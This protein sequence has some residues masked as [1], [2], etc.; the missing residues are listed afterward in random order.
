MMEKLLQELEV[1]DI[2]RERGITTLDAMMGVPLPALA[3]YLEDFDLAK[4]VRTACQKRLEVRGVIFA[5]LKS[6]D[7]DFE[8]VEQ[9]IPAMC[10]EDLTTNHY[11]E[12]YEVQGWASNWAQLLRVTAEEFL[13]RRKASE[14]VTLERID[15]VEE[16][17]R[18]AIGHANCE[19]EWAK[20]FILQRGAA[21][22]KECC[23]KVKEE[24]KG[25]DP[26][27][28][29]NCEAAHVTSE[30]EL[31]RA[32]L[33]REIWEKTKDCMFKTI[34]SAQTGMPEKFKLTYTSV[35]MIE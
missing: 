1:G 15:I 19:F 8:L 27:L 16:A 26:E 23:E 12:L 2:L 21:L 20:I 34:R 17:E 33:I 35:D 13:R 9:I 29:V 5:A 7:V 18:A 6:S 31:R 25:D 14:N 10:V 24:F 3:E 32:T 22:A 11:D 30:I 28:A 4:K